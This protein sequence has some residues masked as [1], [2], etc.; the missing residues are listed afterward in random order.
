MRSERFDVN[1]GVRQRSKSSL[2]LFPVV[3]IK[4]TKDVKG[5]LLKSLMQ[6]T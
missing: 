3:L 6:M 5:G 4:I 2:L 1:V